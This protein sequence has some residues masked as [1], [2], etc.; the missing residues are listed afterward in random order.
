[1]IYVVKNGKPLKK[2]M[3]A[4]KKVDSGVLDNPVYED[5]IKA[6]NQAKKGHVIIRLNKAYN[7]DE[8]TSTLADVLNV[9]PRDIED[10][11]F[12]V[13]DKKRLAKDIKH[14]QKEIFAM[15][16]SKI[17]KAKDKGK[18]TYK[19]REAR[20]LVQ[21]VIDGFASKDDI[22]KVHAQYRKF[23][24]KLIKKLMKA[25]NNGGVFKL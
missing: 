18:D 5:A 4:M 2:L 3:K 22:L 12:D 25:K 6:M 13:S 21:E 15:L 17:E 19:L 1:M 7:L 14:H 23:P 8:V 16:D 10:I 24:K 20:A 11:V 9:E